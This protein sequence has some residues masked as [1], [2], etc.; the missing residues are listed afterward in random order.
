MTFIFNGMWVVCA[1]Q[2]CEAECSTGGAD[3]PGNAAMSE[4]TGGPGGGWRPGGEEGGRERQREDGRE[5]GE[6]EGGRGEEEVERDRSRWDKGGQL[7]K[8]L[9]L[10]YSGM[11][12]ISAS[13]VVIV[14]VPM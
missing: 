9:Q 1:L 7:S 3:L 8:Q 2:A 4:P 10:A 5:G 11:K 6:R 14:L 13:E 12:F